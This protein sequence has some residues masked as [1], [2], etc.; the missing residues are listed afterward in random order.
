MVTAD[1][2][3]DPIGTAVATL[4]HPVRGDLV[5]AYRTSW[6]HVTAPGSWFTG[7]QRRTLARIATEAFEAAEPL[8]P[9]VAPSTEDGVLGDIGD[10]PPAAADAAHR[11]ARHAGT[12]TEE[13]IVGLADRGLPALHYVEVVGVVAAT[14]PVLAFFRGLGGHPPGLPPAGPGEPTGEI[15]DVE[16]GATNWVPVQT[17]ADEFPAVVQAL[18]AVP[19]EFANLAAT[20]G[21]QYVPFDRMLELDWDRGTIDRR[22]IEY[23]AARLSVLRECCY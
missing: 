22:Q 8:P 1:T 5:D 21:A 17:P 3:P 6:R 13:W 20:H 19:G 10:L 4:G 16:H 9:W 15:P 12:V 23:V 14:I 7:E 11:L 18:T 2:S